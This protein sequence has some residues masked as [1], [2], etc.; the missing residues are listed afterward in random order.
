MHNSQISEFSTAKR[1]NVQLQ[2]LHE[3]QQH[4]G[5]KTGISGRA[6]LAKVNGFCRNPLRTG[7]AELLHFLCVSSYSVDDSIT[8]LTAP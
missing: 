6:L 8:S 2:M 3:L 1:L 7:L 4:A 5:D